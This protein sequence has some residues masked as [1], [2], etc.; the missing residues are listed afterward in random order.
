MNNHP[1]P[2][3]INLVR[4]I[5]YIFVCLLYWFSTIDGADAQQLKDRS[6]TNLMLVPC[7]VTSDASV[8]SARDILTN[9]NG[10][11]KHGRLNISIKVFIF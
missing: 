1:W 8:N 6:S 10:A 4:F 3:K 2:F 11:D 9:N 7:D 5:H